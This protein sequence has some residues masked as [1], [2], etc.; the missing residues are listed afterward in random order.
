MTNHNTSVGRTE[1]NNRFGY[2][3]A[4]ATSAPKHAKVRNIFETAAN[5]IDDLIPAGRDKSL[6]LTA[7]QE[8]MHWSNSAIAMQNP[9]D[10]ENPSKP[11][12]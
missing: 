9:V 7:L 2:H 4:D 3:R 1:I 10:N 8:A 11:N 6:A 12:V 5:E